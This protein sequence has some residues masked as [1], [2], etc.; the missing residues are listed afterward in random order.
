MVLLK[1][2]TEHLNVFLQN[3]SIEGLIGLKTFL[4]LSMQFVYMIMKVLVSHR[5]I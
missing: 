5:N 3:K 4:Y 1:G 2:L